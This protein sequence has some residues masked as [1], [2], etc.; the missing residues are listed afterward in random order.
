MII[1]QTYK[2]EFDYV[3]SYAFLY[4]WENA[5][6]QHHEITADQFNKL[7]FAAAFGFSETTA[8]SVLERIA[9]KGIIKINGQLSP[10]TIIKNATSDEM[11]D[12][13]YSSLC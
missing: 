2:S 9:E 10:F 12:Q 6:K 5:Y 3:Y 1:P 8:Y 13:A 7:K 4:E 11:I